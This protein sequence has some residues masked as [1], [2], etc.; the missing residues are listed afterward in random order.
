MEDG[1]KMKPIK[2]QVHIMDSVQKDYYEFEGRDTK[3]LIRLSHDH[4]TLIKDLKLKDNIGIFSH[5]TAMRLQPKTETLCNPRKNRS[6]TRSK[7]SRHLLPPFTRKAS[8]TLRSSQ[9]ET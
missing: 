1:K 9:P 5:L 7:S 6:K 4:E 8:N 3:A 2:V